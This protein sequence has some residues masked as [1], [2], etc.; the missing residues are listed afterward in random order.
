MA[1]N[2]DETLPPFL[3]MTLLSHIGR[4]LR[5]MFEE[6]VNEPVPDRFLQLLDDI[7]SSGALGPPSSDHA[8]PHFSRV[9]P[10]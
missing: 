2:S 1:E 4:L 5:S 7:E 8:P 10:L 6:V 9:D 3:D